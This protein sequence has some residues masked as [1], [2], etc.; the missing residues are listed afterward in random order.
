MK[1]ITVATHSEFYFPWLL[2]SCKRFN[3]DLIKLG[4]GE[5][6]QGFTWRFKLVLEYLKNLPPDEIVCFIDGYDVLLLQPLEKM[7]QIAKHI[8]QETGSKIIIAEDIQ[9]NPIVKV[10]N[11]MYFGQ[12]KSQHLNAGTYIG[13][14]K[15]I[16]EIL[17]NIYATEN[18][19]NNSDDQ[20]L[21]TQYCTKYLNLFY[22]D[23]KN[24]LFVSLLDP[25]RNIK[26]HLTLHEN[27]V[28]YNNAKPF[29]IHA[30][31]LTCMNTLIK[32]LGY[33]MSKQEELS[34][35]KYKCN[36]VV[37]KIMFYSAYFIRT[38]VFIVIVTIFAIIY[39]RKNSKL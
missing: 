7:E 3:V 37:K 1:L 39:K 23:D 36:A 30:P 20:Q 24:Q 11:D 19:S 13:Y 5:K 2:Q 33:Q 9:K 15:D 29:L 16:Y 18:V 28:I 26:R 32:S 31:G 10:L 34:I 14:A 35:Y 22:I 8:L 38:F 17:N 4:W 12:C 6:W 21:L 27:N 25:L